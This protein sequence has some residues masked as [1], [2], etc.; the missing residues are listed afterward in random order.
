MAKVR[1]DLDADLDG[2]RSNLLLMLLGDPRS[3]ELSTTRVSRESSVS[4]RI[5]TVPVHNVENIL[6]C[7]PACS[8][9]C[10]SSAESQPSRPSSSSSKARY[11]SWPPELRT[12]ACTPS[13]PRSTARNSKMG[14]VMLM[15]W[16]EGVLNDDATTTSGPCLKT[17][18]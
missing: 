8:P 6:V 16:M 17:G 9:R 12:I 1:V 2:R 3:T 7:A 15:P 4:R 18:R 5:A 14:V 11:A 13:R 10:N